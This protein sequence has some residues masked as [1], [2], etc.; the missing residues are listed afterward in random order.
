MGKM[1]GAMSVALCAWLLVGCGS[2]RG[3]GFLTEP[4]TPGAVPTVTTPRGAMS[5]PAAKAVMSRRWGANYLDAS[6][7]AALEEQATSKPL[8]AGNK[9]TLLYDGPQTMA[10]MIAAIRAATNHINLETYIFDQDAVG[11]QFAELLMAKQRAG[12]K[13][14]VLYDAVG[15]IGTPDAFFQGMRDAG[16]Q[17][18]A[19]NPINPLKQNGGWDPN[20]RDH[21]KILVV[22]G[23][24][25]FTGGVNISST[26]ANSSLFRSKSRASA[27]V[28]WRDTHVKIEGPA[29]ASLQWEFLNTWFEL[30]ASTLVG[31]N[32]FPPLPKVGDTLVRVLAS[33]PG[34]DQEI[35]R[36]HLLAIRSAKRSIHIT[37]AYFVPD[38]EVRT[39]LSEAALRGVEVKLVLPG[40]SESGPAF[41]AGRAAYHRMLS[42]GVQIYELQIAVLHAKTAVIDGVWST[43]GSA[44]ID[45]RSFLHNLELNVMVFD[46]VFAAALEEA[47]AEDLKSSKE[48]SL[49]QWSERPVAD[50]IK[51]WLA[52]RFGYWL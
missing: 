17:L 30:N 14:H 12:V 31:S 40:V 21:R 8:I 23:K 49:Q 43:V 3:E 41:Y 15:T 45:T 34:G 52:S 27:K 38:E 6:A 25:G 19:F 47:F 35:Y 10:A 28:G 24:V 48:V 2:L 4:P 29:V 18:Q 32:F 5:A 16:I 46:T 11:I 7:V 22:D 26:Y 37:C 44:N 39:A 9:L 13:V 51:E 33:E 1:R 50:R 42:D 20:K 36:A